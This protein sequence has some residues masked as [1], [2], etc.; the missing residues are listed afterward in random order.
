MKGLQD[1]NK[2][3]NDLKYQHKG[4]DLEHHANAVADGIL[5]A[6]WVMTVSLGKAGNPATHAAVK[7]VYF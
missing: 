4:K 3:A 5:V 1:A 6:Q 7:A 2:K